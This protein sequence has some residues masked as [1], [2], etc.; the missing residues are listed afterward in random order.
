MKTWHEGTRYYSYA[1]EVGPLDDFPTAEDAEA[2]ATWWRSKYY[3]D[4]E[5]WRVERTRL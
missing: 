4:A 5:V 2:D 3:K 1:P